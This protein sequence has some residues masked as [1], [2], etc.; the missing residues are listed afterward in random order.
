MLRRGCASTRAISPVLSRTLLNTIMKKTPEKLQKVLAQRGFASRREIERWVE[1]ERITVNGKIAEIGMRVTEN[2]DIAIDGNPIS[3]NVYEEETRVILYHKPPDEICTRKDPEGRRTV[4][5][6][7]PKIK[8]GRWIGIG[9]LDLTT[10]GLL[11]FTNNGDLANKLMHPAQAIEREYLVRV[12]G[13]LSSQ[14]IKQLITGVR[15][16]TGMARFEEIVEHQSQGVNH[17]YFVV[18]VEG[19]NRVVRKLFESQGLMVSRLKRV[20]FGPIFLEKK[21]QQGEWIELK[22]KSIKQL[23]DAAGLE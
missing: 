1:D 15:L 11:L 18:V 3:T 4:Y 19:K 16:D 22:E 14:M 13:K 9:R 12:C 23:L 2:D 10:S 5:Q 8:P 7:L 17:W 6:S 20:R 21:C